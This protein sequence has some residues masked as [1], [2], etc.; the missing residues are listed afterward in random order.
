MSFFLYHTFCCNFCEATKCRLWIA[1][2]IWDFKMSLSFVS[3]YNL[4][5]KIK[6]LVSSN[7]HFLRSNN[8]IWTAIS[9][10]F[11]IAFD[12]FCNFCQGTNFSVSLK[13]CSREYFWWTPRLE[14]VAFLH[15]SVYAMGNKLTS[16]TMAALVKILKW[17]N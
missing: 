7:K 14:I 6:P 2:K 16:S 17:S 15:A 10:I 3:I 1:C 4:F 5:L 9:L 11:S 8:F 13:L 12:I